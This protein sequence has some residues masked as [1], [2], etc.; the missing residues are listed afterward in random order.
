[1]SEALDVEWSRHPTIRKIFPPDSQKV[2]HCD[3]SFG[4]PYNQGHTCHVVLDRYDDG[5][6]SDNYLV[7]TV[8]TSY[9]Q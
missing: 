8:T 3:I 2:V 6:T 7:G 4:N 1:M 5:T 9:N